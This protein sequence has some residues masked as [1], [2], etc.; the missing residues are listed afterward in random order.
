[1][2]E[3]FAPDAVNTEGDKP[4][5]DSTKITETDIDAYLQY[6]IPKLANPSDDF[7]ASDNITRETFALAVI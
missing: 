4:V 2:V 3:K 7:I 6:I 1:L 5:V